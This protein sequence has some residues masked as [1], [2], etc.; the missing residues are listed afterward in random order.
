MT[1][2]YEWIAIVSCSRL[3][4]SAAMSDDAELKKCRQIIK[5][6]TLRVPHDVDEIDRRPHR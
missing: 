2:A 5:E 4:S 1:L 3:A 6:W